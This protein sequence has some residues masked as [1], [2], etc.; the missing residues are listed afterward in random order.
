MGMVSVSGLT[1]EELVDYEFHRFCERGVLLL[2]VYGSKK[3]FRMK[4]TASLF[5]PWF[6]LL[7]CHR[8]SDTPVEFKQL[9][10]MRCQNLVAVLETKHYIVLAPLQSFMAELGQWVH[11][12]PYISEDDELLVAVRQVALSQ[13]RTHG[14]G[15]LRADSV[16]KARGLAPRLGYR[17]SD[18]LRANKCLVYNKQRKLIE[19]NCREIVLSAPGAYEG[20]GFTVSHDTLLTVIDRVY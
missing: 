4:R 3:A 2:G 17:T 14:F 5:F 16:A 9:P 20:H 1:C 7:A 19:P 10:A 6:F 12:H 8:A 13:G 18:L 11:K 15:V